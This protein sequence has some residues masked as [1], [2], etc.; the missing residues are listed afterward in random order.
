MK[1]KIVDIVKDGYTPE[2]EAFAFLLLGGKQGAGFIE[3]PNRKRSVEDYG[4]YLGICIVF[5]FRRMFLR[6]IREGESRIDEILDYLSR[7][8][9]NFKIVESW[10]L[11]AIENIPDQKLKLISIEMWNEIKEKYSEQDFDLAKLF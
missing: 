10:V 3:I 6:F 11:E 9:K 5:Q 7:V 2:S 4:K 8:G 1:N